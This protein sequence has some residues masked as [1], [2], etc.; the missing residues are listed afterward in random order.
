[1]PANL[2]AAPSSLNPQPFPPYP[3]KTPRAFGAFLAFFQLGQT[4]SHQAVADKLG[5]GLPAVKHWASKMTDHSDTVQY[6]AAGLKTNTNEEGLGGN[7][8]ATALRYLVA[9]ES[10]R[11]Y[12]VKLTGLC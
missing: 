7:D 10:R 11:I 6:A 4:R 12:Q 9:A 2:S 3:G 1:V 8:A 5:E